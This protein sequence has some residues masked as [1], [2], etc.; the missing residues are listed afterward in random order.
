[1]TKYIPFLKA[2]SNEIIAIGEL[3]DI[4]LSEII[5]FFDLPKSKDTEDEEGFIKDVTRISKSIDKHL[6]DATELYFDTYDVN[7]E[8]DVE[9][10][11][12]YLYLLQLLNSEKVIPVVSVDRSPEHIEAV[13]IY[14]TEFD[15]SN[16]VIALRLTAEDFENYSVTIDDI[17]EMLS[18]TLQLFNAVDLIFDCRMCKN[19]KPTE[20]AEKIKTFSN[21]IN[22]N[23]TI[24][25]FIITGSS[26][27]ASISDTLPVASEVTINRVEAD[28]FDQASNN[29]DDIEYLYG[30]YTIVSPEYSDVDIEPE[31]MQ[32]VI[33]A[34]FAYT[35][36]NKHFFIR[37]EGLK[38]KGYD[39]YFTLAAELCSKPFYRGEDYSE[40]DKYFHE[41]SLS[42][43]SNGTPSAVIKPSVNAHVSFIVKDYL[44]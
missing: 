7:Y 35:Y 26:I 17:E 12:H 44:S 25:H 34:K 41:K 22:R 8:F 28:V 9:G 39:Q 18:E 5:P 10:T 4:V 36:E 14:K 30:D 38:T 19:L 32:S 11:H 3:K 27:P 43:G 33:T 13:K 1:M 20:L 15:Q 37:G 24:R 16:N 40:G 42:K 6:S 21:D 2:K 31:I 29:S 23:F